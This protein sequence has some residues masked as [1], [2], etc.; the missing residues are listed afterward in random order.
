MAIRRSPIL[1][2]HPEALRHFEKVPKCQTRNFGEFTSRDIFGFDQKSQQFSQ[3]RV[4][5]GR[6]TS[7]ICDPEALRK[8]PKCQNSKFREFTSRDFLV[9]IKNLNNSLR[10]EL[11]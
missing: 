11:M 6:T 4:H 10:I 5:V 2:S 9:L 1:Y 8:C 3:N 7:Q